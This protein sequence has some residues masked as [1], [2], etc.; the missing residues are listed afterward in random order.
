MRNNGKKSWPKGKTKLI[1]GT[2]SVLNEKEIILHPQA[3]G[4]IKSYDI[5]SRGLKIINLNNINHL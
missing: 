4:E 1:P 3:P 5:I 2:Y